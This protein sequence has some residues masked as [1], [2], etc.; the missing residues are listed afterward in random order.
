MI[1]QVNY[2]EWPEFITIVIGIV[3]LIIA[4]TSIVFSKISATSERVAITE[5]QN[6][7]DDENFKV[8]YRKIDWLEKERVSDKFS[9]MIRLT[10]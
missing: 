3:T 4:I 8:I 2:V 7:G 1:A 9:T 5:K 10:D 6:E